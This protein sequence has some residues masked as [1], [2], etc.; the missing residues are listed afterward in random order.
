[1]PFTRA[2]LAQYSR[3]QT[4][5]EQIV[6]G[7]YPA[8]HEESLDLRRFFRSYV[9]T[10]VERDLRA[11]AAVQDLGRF[12]QFL[13]LLAGRIGQLVN[14]S[15][16]SSDVGVSSTTLRAWLNVLKACYLVVELPPWHANIRKRLTRSAKLYFTDT[17]LACFLLGIDSAERLKVDRMRGGLFENHV[18]MDIWKTL[19]HLGEVPSLFFYR[20]SHGHE[21]DLLIQRSQQIIPVEIKSSETFSASFTAGL[22]HFAG[23]VDG[24]ADSG[25][26]VYAGTQPFIV[27]GV[28]I[29]PIDQFSIRDL[30]PISR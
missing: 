13:T 6:T 3:S 4:V 9:Q 2:E 18:I 19:L 25:L 14:L 5:F 28:R 29:T 16:L 11:L 8:I 10:Y 20:D 15:A 22:K 7:G 24:A 12:Q 26:I 1:M 27:D 23:V 17:G 21:V 30:E